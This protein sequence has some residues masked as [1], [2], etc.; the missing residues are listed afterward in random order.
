MRYYIYAL[1][2]GVLLALASIPQMAAASGPSVDIPVAASFVVSG[3][4]RATDNVSGDFS[5]GPGR[6]EVVRDDRASYVRLATPAGNRARLVSLDDRDS[7]IS[8]RNNTFLLPLYAAGEKAGALALAT[9]GL[10]ADSYG[11]AGMITGI[12]LDSR[13]IETGRDGQNFTADVLMSLTDLPAGAAYRIAF[14]GN[15]SMEAAVADELN[16]FGLAAAAT[17]P[18]LEISAS[19]AVAGSAIGFVI[20]T[21]ETEENWTGTY[22]DRSLILYHFA[23]D[24][25]SRLPFSSIRTGTGGMAYQAIAP[26]AGHLVIVAPASQGMAKGEAAAVDG[27]IILLG[28][29][30]AVLVIALGAMIR[31]VLKR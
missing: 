12:Q 27:D 17:T 7:G 14:E 18:P 4:A 19:N 3:E 29:L 1:A 9:D 16:A 21:I 13:K 5:P 31:R 6:I 23:G 25:L 30:L 24:R 26:G 10:T 28:C 8:F 2:L 22:G 15:A 20:V 11:Y